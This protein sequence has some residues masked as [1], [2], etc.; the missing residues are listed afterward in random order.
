MHAEAIR[1]LVEYN[2]WATHRL[3]AAAEQCAPEQ[4]TASEP[5]SW[6]S[7]M[8]TFGHILSAEWAWRQRCQLGVSP[9]KMLDPHQ[10]AALAALRQRWDAEESALRGYVN[11]LSDADLLRVVEYQ[12]TSG[13]PFR[14]VLW[15]I[16]LHVVNHG[17]QHRGE[18]AL[19]LTGFG[20]SPGDIDLSVFYAET[21]G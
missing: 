18:I 15:Q 19:Y 9:T 6:D 12:N 17:T 5:M 16:L 20:H 21:M 3:L 1:L 7:V 11:G 10:F 2:Y 8:G 4:L 13:K 14:R